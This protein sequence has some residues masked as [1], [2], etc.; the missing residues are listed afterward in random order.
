MNI[1]IVYD[2]APALDRVMEIERVVEAYQV[3]AI[4]SL[5]AALETIQ[6]RGS[7]SQARNALQQFDGYDYVAQSWLTIKSA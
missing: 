7:F 5:E 1:H 2:K 3:G 4:W 6:I